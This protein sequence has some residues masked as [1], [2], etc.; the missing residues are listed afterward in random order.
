M[1]T[2]ILHIQ[3]VTLFSFALMA[4]L[5]SSSEPTTT[6]AAPGVYLLLS[7][8]NS[9]FGPPKAKLHSDHLQI[10]LFN[11]LLLSLFLLGTS[12]SCMSLLIVI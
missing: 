11:C 5:L 3:S 1:Y 8:I 6:V 7:A 12:C 10:F 2:S 9:S 4:S